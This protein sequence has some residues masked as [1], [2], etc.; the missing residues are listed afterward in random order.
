M[1]ILC[2]NCAQTFGYVFRSRRGCLDRWRSDIQSIQAQ[3]ETYLDY[4]YC[5]S[6]IF[7]ER[8]C[9]NWMTREHWPVFDL[10]LRRVCNICRHCSLCLPHMPRWP[11]TLRYTPTRWLS[12]CCQYAIGLF[13]VFWVLNL[14]KNNLACTTAKKKYYS[15]KDSHF[16]T[17]NVSF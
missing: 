3:I 10:R 14:G 13:L 8:A 9:E 2:P 16:Y 12:C 11:P 7:N 4:I 6:G 1:A 17:R 15:Q 5:E